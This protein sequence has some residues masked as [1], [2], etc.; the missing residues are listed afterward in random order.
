MN[1][2]ILKLRIQIL[3]LKYFL[4]SHSDTHS[5][6]DYCFMYYIE[7]MM[8]ILTCMNNH[9]KNKKKRR[10]NRRN[11]VSS[12]IFSRKSFGVA[13]N[14]IQCQFLYQLHLHEGHIYYHWQYNSHKKTEK[15]FYT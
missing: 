11:M 6:I 9:V 13:L 14:N 2:S 15:N 8:Y 10:K 3:I 7:R 1:F 4:I 12:I 5:L